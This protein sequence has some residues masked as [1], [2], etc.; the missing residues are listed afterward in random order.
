MNNDTMTVPHT[1]AESYGLRLYP[2]LHCGYDDG[3][4]VS[5]DTMFHVSAVCPNCRWQSESRL[6]TDIT[7]AAYVAG[8][9]WNKH[10]DPV[11]NKTTAKYIRG[12]GKL[13]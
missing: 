12:K 11:K 1:I 3:I 7:M 4:Q 5:F 10:M 8:M 9:A 2:C 13:K 6:C